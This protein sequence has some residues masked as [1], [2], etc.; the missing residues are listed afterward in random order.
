M[1]AL[2]LSRAPTVYSLTQLGEGDAPSLP[3]RPSSAASASAGSEMPISEI[4]GENLPL[5]RFVTKDSFASK[6][7]RS[8]GDIGAIVPDID[9]RSR[10]ISDDDVSLME[11]SSDS[12]S[13]IQEVPQRSVMDSLLLAE[14]ED[15]AEAG[16]F[17][18]DVT[19]CETCVLQGAYGFVAQLNEGRAS[20]KRPTEFRVDKVDQPFDGSKFNFTKAMVHEALFEFQAGT[21]RDAP[22]FSPSSIVHSS[23]NVV[24]INVSPIEYGHVLLVPRVLDKLNQLVSPESMR[25]AMFFARE[26]DNPYF[27]VGFNSLGAYATINHLH[28][29]AYYLAAPMALERAATTPLPNSLTRLV[30]SQGGSDLKSSRIG[31]WGMRIGQ[32]DGYAVRGL[33]YEAGESIEEVA[34]AVGRACQRLTARNIPHNLMIVDRGARVFLIPNAFAKRKARGELPQDIVDSMVDP[35][36]FEISG[37]IV[38]KRKEDYDVADQDWAWRLLEYASYSEEEFEEVKGICVSE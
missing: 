16:L 14:W 33:V 15:R 36:V 9:D 7:I 35:A 25:L 29:Q 20:K 22:S 26:A 23:P 10:T 18:Y 37:H 12:G 28:F 27:R 17:R 2:T 31:G 19:A 32:L 24:L 6:R 21:T 8:F 1:S 13:S 38:L 11:G 3:P 30:S 5:Y 4:I 34:D